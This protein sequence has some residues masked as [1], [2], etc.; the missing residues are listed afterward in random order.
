MNEVYIEY[1]KSS[2]WIERRK[3][4]MEEAEEI[5]DEC[6]EKATVLH[7]LN[8]NN[9]GFELLG[10][11]VVALCKECHKDMHEDNSNDEYGEY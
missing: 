5:C 2:D 10:E 3:E 8:Y 9:L 1:L 6:G 11:D 4:L 7:H